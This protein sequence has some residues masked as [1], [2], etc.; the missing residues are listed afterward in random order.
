MFQKVT[1]MFLSLV[2]TWLEYVAS[3]FIILIRLW[4]R[5]G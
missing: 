5:E 3:L 4:V 2:S 1:G